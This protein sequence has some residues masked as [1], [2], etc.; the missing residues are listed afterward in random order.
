MVRI[1]IINLEIAA[2]IYL[3]EAVWETLAEVVS[4]QIRIFQVLV[5]CFQN[6]HVRLLNRTI[7]MIQ[8]WQEPIQISNKKMRNLF[9]VFKKLQKLLHSVFF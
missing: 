8:D 5:K 4:H 9:K 7:I 6:K 1:F 3:R 2:W